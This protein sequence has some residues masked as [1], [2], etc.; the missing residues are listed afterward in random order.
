MI[1]VMAGVS[2]TAQNEADKTVTRSHVRIVTVK[3]GV[4]EIMDTVYTGGE[5]DVLFL[6]GNRDFS[7]TTGNDSVF[8]RHFT[9]EGDTSKKVIM[10]RDMAGKERTG[11]RLR[12]TLAPGLPLPPTPPGVHLFQSRPAH[13]I[14]L[15]DPGIISFKK[16][17]LSG[18]REK[19][20]VI[21]NQPSVKHAEDIRIIKEENDNFM[22]IPTPGS[23]E[24]PGSPV[25]KEIEIRKQ[26]ESK[27]GESQNK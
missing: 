24:K 9:W 17:K 2:V 21:R 26:I 3:D 13:V 8:S 10:I 27:T 15:A 20:T 1:W 22:H 4:T 11:E 6:K 12:A 7:F 18:G 5:S 16:K 14:D 25:R 23:P 19:I